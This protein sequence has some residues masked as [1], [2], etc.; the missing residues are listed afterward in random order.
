MYNTANHIQTVVSLF[1][2]I[3][4]SMS[5]AVILHSMENKGSGDMYLHIFF[6]VF[7]YSINDLKKKVVILW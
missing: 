1:C 2:V 4:E 3:S 5:H 7:G 6:Q